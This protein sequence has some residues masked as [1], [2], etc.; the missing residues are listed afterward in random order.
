MFRKEVQEAR[1]CAEKAINLDPD[2]EEIQEVV[3]RVRSV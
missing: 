2:N 3:N 1:E